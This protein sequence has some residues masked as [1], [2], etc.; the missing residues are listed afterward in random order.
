MGIEIA[1]ASLD[2]AA[3]DP[4]APDPAAPDP[5]VNA[6]AISSPA[7][8]VRLLL[9]PTPAM[10]TDSRIEVVRFQTTADLEALLASHMPWCD[11]LIMAAAVADYRPKVQAL[12]Q[13]LKRTAAGLTLE[14]EGTPDLLAGVSRTRRSDQLLVGFALEP[15]ERLEASARDK[16]ARK[17]LDLIVANEL[18]TMDAADVRAW[19]LSK[20][21][22][23][24]QTPGHVSKI[25][26]A[27]MLMERI[28][29]AWRELH[30][31]AGA[32]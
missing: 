25:A 30:S 4:A 16:L 17:G 1:Q 22:S 21:G 28:D 14:L 8:E 15:A 29:A 23:T 26:F 13:K 5:A 31:G 32:R 9:G 6:A 12:D 19:V 3:L 10:P 7:R 18:A 24:W 11:V 27:K 2:P 20:G